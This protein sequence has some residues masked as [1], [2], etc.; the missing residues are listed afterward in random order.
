MNLKIICGKVF[1]ADLTAK[2]KEALQIE[3]RKILAEEA[4]KY[5]D[6]F[7]AC[8]LYQIHAQ[9][10][11]QAKALRKFYDQWKVIHRQLLDYYE[12]DKPDAPWLFMQKLKDIGVDVEEWN[13]ENE[14]DT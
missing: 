11:K 14:D 5:E 9:Y 3:A 2:E 6:D 4:R 1:G 13:K 12:L 7:D 10:G 8:V